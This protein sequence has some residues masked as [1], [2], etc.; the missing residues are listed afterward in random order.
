[1]V[2]KATSRLNLAKIS[3][4]PL[5]PIKHD[6]KL[7]HSQKTYFCYKSKTSPE[8]SFKFKLMLGKSSPSFLRKRCTTL[9]PSTSGPTIFPAL[10]WI[11]PEVTGSLT[12]SLL[13]ATQEPHTCTVL[14]PGRQSMISPLVGTMCALQWLVPNIRT[15][16]NNS[17]VGVT[18]PTQSIERLDTLS[19]LRYCSP[20]RVL[21]SPS[22]TLALLT[23]LFGLLPA[24]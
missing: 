1:M 20:L 11:Q 7:S 21:S 6:G 19:T 22:S 12:A 10:V 8:E 9:F 18:V 2:K 4:F 24:V 17:W 13:T 23:S 5:T 16:F 3:T 15:K 14:L